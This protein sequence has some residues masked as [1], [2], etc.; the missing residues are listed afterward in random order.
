MT[1]CW[2]QSMLVFFVFV[3]EERQIPNIA[4]PQN[5]QIDISNPNS[6]RTQTL[7]V[8]SFYRCWLV[9]LFTLFVRNIIPCT[10]LEPA[11]YKQSM[12]RIK[13]SLVTVYL[14]EALM[15]EVRPSTSLIQE[16][17]LIYC[18]QICFAVCHLFAPYPL[19]WRN[20]CFE[21]LLRNILDVNFRPTSR[22]NIDSKIFIVNDPP[23]NDY[24]K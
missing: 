6:D 8:F 15:I 1:F 23:Q 3:I 22:S 4:S 9:F 12:Y 2:L 11:E 19:F 24:W 7:V 13:A 5:W 21:N 18:L 20:L 10:E 16:C 14:Y 17:V